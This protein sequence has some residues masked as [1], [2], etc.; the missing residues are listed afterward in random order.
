MAATS[1]NV[2]LIAQMWQSRSVRP[3]RLR[4]A[5]LELAVRLGVQPDAAAKAGPGS[6]SDPHPLSNRI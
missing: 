6:P 1:A 4:H 5:R 3:C 2:L